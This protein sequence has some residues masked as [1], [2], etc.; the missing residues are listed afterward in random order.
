V[1]SVILSG[2][3]AVGKTTIA[4]LLERWMG[5][6]YVSGGDMLKLMAEERG[7]R[8]GG[9]DWWDGEDGQRF[10]MERSKDSRFDL[11]VDER[12]KKLA[13]EGGY[14]ITS[15]SLPW[16]TR[17]GI[18]VWLKAS[19]EAR[20]KRMAKRDK[21]DF[22]KALEIVEKRDEKNKA[23]YKKLYGY[24]FESDLSVFHLVVDTEK[25]SPEVIAKVIMTFLEG[26][27]G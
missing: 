17:H 22:E 2:P 26:Y 12:L 20:A 19:R 4:K 14:V 7:Y 23:L 1:L 9:D 6:K 5:L 25:L 11:E 21:I 13:E 18:K 24:D 3:P 27:E 10:L 15:Y 16:L 8:V